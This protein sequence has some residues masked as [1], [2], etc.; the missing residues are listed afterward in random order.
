[1]SVP[2]IQT[3]S[4]ERSIGRV[5]GFL[6]TLDKGSVWYQ[7]LHVRDSL[8]ILLAVP[9]ERWEVEFFEDGH[10]ELER[11]RSTSDIDHVTDQGLLELI[12]P[13]LDD[14]PAAD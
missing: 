7:L 14:E 11:F 2:E 13:Y 10:I 3:R 8:M 6:E 1:M 9:G 4:H 5:I 12:K